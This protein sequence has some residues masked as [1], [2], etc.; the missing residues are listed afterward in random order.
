MSVRNIK[1][2][3]SGSFARSRRARLENNGLGVFKASLVVDYE[4]IIR[5]AVKLFL[6][7]LVHCAVHFKKF[8][9]GGNHEECVKKFYRPRPG[10]G[11]GA[12]LRRAFP[13][14]VQQV[15]SAGGKTSAPA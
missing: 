12:P 5:Y 11:P 3:P 9:E 10:N 13:F 8:S 2:W 1:P 4:N 14:R 15:R 6:K 7:C